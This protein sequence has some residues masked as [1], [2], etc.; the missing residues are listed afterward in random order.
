V[1]T[2]LVLP[3]GVLRSSQPRV[4]FGTATALPEKTPAP[5]IKHPRTDPFVAHLEQGT[6]ELL[7][8]GTGDSHYPSTNSFDWWKPDGTRIERLRYQYPSG[9]SSSFGGGDSIYRQLV[10]RT[11]E[12]PAGSS[13]LSIAEVETARSYGPV[14]PVYLD[15]KIQPGIT[16]GDLELPPT[17]KVTRIKISVATAPWVMSPPVGETFGPGASSGIGF[18]NAGIHWRVKFQDIQEINGATKII[19]YHTDRKGWQSELFFVDREGKEWV[20][21]GRAE[22]SDGLRHLSGTINLPLSRIKAAYLRIRPYES[23]E[24]RNVSLVPDQHTDVEI[25]EAPLKTSLTPSSEIPEEYAKTATKRIRI[26]K[27]TEENHRISAWTDSNFEPGEVVDAVVKLPDGRLE[28][29]MVQTMTIRGNSGRRVTTAFSWQLPNSFDLE[30]L[31]AA[32]LLA[33]KNSALGKS[34]VLETGR[35]LS[36]F[37]AANSAGGTIEAILMF[38]RT[39]HPP[40]PGSISPEAFMRFTMATNLNQMVLCY[41][42]PRV[43]GGNIL[44]AVAVISGRA[45]A[46]AHTSIA[47]SA[48][49]NAG[50]CRFDFPVEFTAREMQSAVEQIDQIKKKGLIVIALNTRLKL[51]SVTNNASATYEGFFELRSP[52]FKIGNNSSSPRLAKQRPNPADRDEALQVK[53]KFAEERVKEAQAKLAVGVVSPLEYEKEVGARDILLAEMKGDAVEAA[54]I[55]LRVAESEFSAAERRHAN[56]VASAEEYENAKLARDLAAISLRKL[57]KVKGP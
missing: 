55:K 36:L 33:Q 57:E 25:I 43:Y 13:P 45:E 9:G 10:L 28:D 2:V 34:I 38:W 5:P 22:S 30:T 50:D 39:E 4:F 15:G 23:V 8:V 54:R 16:M 29:A 49:Y 21:E 31:N 27:I 41:F 56:G 35:S 26:T 32:K 18:D 17:T 53:L 51:F 42:D 11:S 24:F 7:A 37:T 44:E 6:I 48:H 46:E 14:G 3:L 12:L 40:R 19:A 1:G 52:H 47:H 20:P